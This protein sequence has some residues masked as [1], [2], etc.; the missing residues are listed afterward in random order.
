MVLVPMAFVAS[1]LG[2]WTGDRTP[3]TR[4]ISTEVLTPT[5]E[6]GGI[7]QVRYVVQRD[8]TCDT[9]ADRM[10]FDS[11]GRRKPL[12]DINSAGPL[13]P[14]TYIA[15][16]EVPTWFALGKARY[17]TSSVFT[18]NPLHVLFPIVATPREI[19]VEVVAPR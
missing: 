9:R 12:D 16:A 15:T 17:V 19:E 14:T 11:E 5:V 13:G 2:T 6:P 7:I 8:R 10:L 4:L 1:V 3:P 18:C